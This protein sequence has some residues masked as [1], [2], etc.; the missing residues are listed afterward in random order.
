MYYYSTQNRGLSVNFQEAVFKSL[1]DDNGLYFPSE[2][3]KLPRDVLS[4]LAQL[5]IEE[6]GL[7]MMRPFVAGEIPDVQLQSI[8]SESVNFELPIKAIS[9]RVSVLELFHGPT[10]AFK[11]VG[12]RFLARCM[13][14]FTSKKDL[15]THILVATSGDT[16]GAV[17]AGFY[18]VPGV[19][20]TILFPKGKVSVVQ[21]LQL[22]TWGGNISAI[23]ID[24]SF[25]DCQTLVKQAFLDHDLRKNQ[26][27]SSANSINVARFLPQSIYYARI[28]QE[29]TEQSL[30]V[31]VP[32]GNYGNLTA[33]LFAKRMGLPI[34]RFIAATNDN[35]IVPDY[36][37]TGSYVAQPSISTHANAMDVGDPSNFKR[38]LELFDDDLSAMQEV[39]SGYSLTNDE[40]L[41]A[42]TDCY[43]S[44]GYTADPHGVIGYSALQKGL[45]EDEQGVFL[46]TAHPV[47]FANVMAQVNL[48]NVEFEELSKTLEGKVMSFESLANDFN[49]L[50][51]YL[52]SVK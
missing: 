40:I 35:R 45:K 34:K 23:E 4:H 44:S 19:R 16:G 18:K 30:V 50:K 38:M 6:I 46:E 36:L 37:E 10:W 14:Y 22:T 13:G 2:I 28:C 41:S 1:P 42:L 31:A 20:V 3:P 9:D 47:K 21:Q 25:D 7:H 43:Q 32:S 29:F 27:L 5:S 15:R 26:H 8:V 39:I 52:H 11:D 24:G 17:A 48:Q 49:L 51:D 12:A 33:G